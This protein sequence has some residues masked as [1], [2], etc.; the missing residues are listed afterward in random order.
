MVTIGIARHP[1]DPVH[2]LWRSHF[3]RFTK[4][5][6]IFALICPSSTRRAAPVIP[7]P[8]SLANNKSGPSRSDGS[9]NLLL[10]MLA[11]NFCPAGESKNSELISVRMY[12]GCMLFTRIPCRAHSRARARVMWS[13]AA[14]LIAYV[15]RLFTTCKE[16]QA[17]INNHRLREG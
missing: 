6:H 3:G 11:M 4:R 16:R 2:W 12:P 17:G 1:V 7:F 9:P 5:F 15:D 13:S 14:L 8:A 10:G